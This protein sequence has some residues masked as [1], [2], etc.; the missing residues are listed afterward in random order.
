MKKKKKKKKNVSGESWE[1]AI[2]SEVARDYADVGD[3]IMYPKF[4]V[5]DRTDIQEAGRAVD[6]YKV[7][8]IPSSIHSMRSWVEEAKNIIPTSKKWLISVWRRVG[9]SAKT[10]HQSLRNAWGT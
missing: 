8:G 9:G 6:E 4:V 10:T 3:S 7:L 1:T 5:A 2:K